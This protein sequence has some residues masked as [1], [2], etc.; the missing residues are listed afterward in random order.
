MNRLRVRWLTWL[1]L[2][3]LLGGPLQAATTVRHLMWDANQRPLYQLCATEFQARNPDLQIRL[4]QLGWDDYW[5]AL[6]TG[7]ISGT[8]PDVFTNHVVHFPEFAANGVMV[9]LAPLLR[10]DRLP[11]DTYEPG[12]LE[13]WQ[14]PGRQYGLPTDWDTIA[15]AVNL[16]HLRAAGVDPARLRQLNWNPR[17]GGSLGRLIERLTVDE[18]GRRADEPGFDR[19]RVRH[20]GYQNPGPGGMTG[21]TEWSHF[22]V[23]AGWRFHAQPWDPALRYDDP[24]LVQTLDWLATLPARGLSATPAALGKLGADAF[25]LGGRVAIVPSGTWMIGHFQRHARFPHAWVPLPVGPTGQ[26]ASM[27]NGLALSIWSGSPRVEAAWRW[28]RYVG[29]RECQARIAE[30]GVI[31][32]AIQGL[33]E[34][35]VEAQ[36]RRGIDARA[37]L[38]AARGATFPPPLVHRAAEVHDLMG[39]AFERILSGSARAGQVLPEAAGRVRAITREP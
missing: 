15:L 21:Q 35:A 17:D 29:S 14:A 13:L 12:L 10:R 5:P 38:E 32:P 31:Y 24:V 11:I 25:F 7:F 23:S 16:D 33:G 22:A 3:L 28:V 8:A 18:Q 20:F 2:P 9:D 37:F 6:S 27:R 4:Q 1:L 30:A 39:S 34:V 19:R 36:R 26:R